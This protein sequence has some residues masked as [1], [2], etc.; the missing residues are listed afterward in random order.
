MKFSP[1]IRAVRIA[2]GSNFLGNRLDL[3]KFCGIA[4]PIVGFEHYEICGKTFAPHPHAGFSAV[5]YVLEDSLGA[6][7]SR[8]SLGNDLVV[9]PGELI[10]TQSGSGIIHDEAPETTGS[11][12]HG[13]QF[14]VNVSGKHKHLEPEVF[15]LSQNEI[16]NSHDQ[17]ENRVRILAGRFG[18][19]AA[20][21]NLVESFDFFDV[22]LKLQMRFLL[23]AKRAVLFYVLAGAIEVVAEDGSRIVQEH[24]AVALYAEE[25]SDLAICCGL[26]LPDTSMGG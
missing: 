20:A 4:N 16:S 21:I 11:R 5:S 23:A 9:K 6:L 24:E 2:Q 15:H 14:F 8:D 13:V 18:A 22:W 1:V 26:I 17:I 7:R 19:H 3:L 10:W 12:V 25:D